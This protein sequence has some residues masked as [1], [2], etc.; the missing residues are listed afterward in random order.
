MAGTHPALPPSPGAAPPRHPE[1]SS[2]STA[3]PHLPIAPGGDS[4]GLREGLCRHPRCKHSLMNITVV[5]PPVCGPTEGGSG[6]S[7]ELHWPDPFRSANLQ[8]GTQGHTSVFSLCLPG[9]HQ[10]KTD[11]SSQGR[12]RLYPPPGVCAATAQDLPKMGLKAPKS[13]PA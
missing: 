9:T 11:A 13:L 5:I 8:C 6:Y 3:A 4:P 12:G 10:A 7:H 2:P 1:L